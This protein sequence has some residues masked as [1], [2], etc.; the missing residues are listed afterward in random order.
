MSLFSFFLFSFPFFLSLSLSLSRSRARAL[1]LP[2]PSS[3]H[4]LQLLCER[5][6]VSSGALQQTAVGAYQSFIR[7]Y[8][9]Y[10]SAVK[11]I[12]HIRNLHLGHVAKSFALREPPGELQ[13]AGQMTPSLTPDIHILSYT[14]YS[15]PRTPN[16]HT[17]VPRIFIPSYPGY[18]YPRTPD[19][20]IGYLHLVLPR[21]YT[22]VASK[23]FLRHYSMTS[24][25]LLCRHLPLYDVIYCHLPL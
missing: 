13:V 16:I 7:A 3:L 17:L 2:T 9:T 24:L 12:F 11:R 21:I 19:I 15:Y 23:L 18:S 14:G 1:S 8:A 25:S 22:F 6:V 5:A 4:S 20:H 10:P